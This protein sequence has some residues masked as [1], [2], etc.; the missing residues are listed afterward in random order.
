ML[1]RPYHTHD[2]KVDLSPCFPKRFIGR[3]EGGGGLVVVI[4]G[5]TIMKSMI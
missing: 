3:M 1:L 5:E 2:R 4:L